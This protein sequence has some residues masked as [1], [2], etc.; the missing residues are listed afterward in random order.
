MFLYQLQRNLQ[1]Y[2]EGSC[3][4]FTCASA[5]PKSVKFQTP[6]WAG[7]TYMERAREFPGLTG[8]EISPALHLV[9]TCSQ[10]APVSILLISA[11]CLNALNLFTRIKLY[12]LH[13]RPDPVSSPNA[14]FVSAQLDFEPLEPP[15]LPS[16][17]RASLWFSFSYS[18]RF[19]L[20]MQPPARHDQVPGKMS[21]VQ[22]IDV[23]TPGDMEIVLFAIY[24]PAHSLMWMAT[25][26][27]NWIFMIILMAL[28]GVQVCCYI[29][30]LCRAWI[31][32]PSFMHKPGRST[33]Y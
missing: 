11:S 28:V 8:W 16:R 18:W 26:S 32:R 1:Y 13:H 25:G 22:Q 31:L 21:R 5:L 7:K 30:S 33:R 15:S 12:R 20:G 29:L 10:T 14:R 17:I 9:L 4:S 19:L 2:W 24:S 27:S 23:W 3:T 6:N